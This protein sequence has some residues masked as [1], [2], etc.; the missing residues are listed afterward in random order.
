MT[1]ER[2][3]EKME[4]RKRQ[5]LSQSPEYVGYAQYPEVIPYEL[6]TLTGVYERG[7]AHR[8]ATAERG[9]E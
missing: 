5:P 1:K 3:F 8:V 4:K 2:A 9:I 7:G 6:P